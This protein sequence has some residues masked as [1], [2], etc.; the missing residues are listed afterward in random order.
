M[1]IPD[2]LLHRLRGVDAAIWAD[3]VSRDA[4]AGLEHEHVAEGIEDDGAGAPEA[5]KQLSDLPAGGEGVGEAIGGDVGAARGEGDLSVGCK[6][7]VR[8]YDPIGS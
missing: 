8:K 3:G 4:R 1:I 2:I 5:A 6:L 7:G